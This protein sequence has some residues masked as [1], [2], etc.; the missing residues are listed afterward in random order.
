[1]SLLLRDGMMIC[2]DKYHQMTCRHTSMAV[3]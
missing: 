2:D 1:M 3:Q